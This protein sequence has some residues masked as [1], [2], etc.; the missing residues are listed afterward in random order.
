MRLTKTYLNSDEHF[1]L[2]LNFECTYLKADQWLQAVSAVATS[3]GAEQFAADVSGV[4]LEAAAEA[5]EAAGSQALA[6]A[7]GTSVAGSECFPPQ[8]HQGGS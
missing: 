3:S 4:P 1:N 8:L 2:C 6:V 7:A 5:S